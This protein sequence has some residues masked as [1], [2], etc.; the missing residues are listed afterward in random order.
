MSMKERRQHFRIDDTVFFDYKIIQSNE[1]CADSK[2]Y[3]QLLGEEGTRHLEAAKFF[4]DID[5]ELADISQSISNQ[6]PDILNFLKLINAKVDF[7]R[8]VFFSKDKSKLRPVNLGLGGM[9]FKTEK[10]IP[11]DSH[12]IVL[13]Y[14]KPKMIP[15]ILE[16]RVVYSKL[17]D[18]TGYRTAIA[19]GEL[20]PEKEKILANHIMQIQTQ[21]K[22]D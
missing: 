15:L 7:M 19:F 9:S 6:Y 5:Q 8:R 11:M 21:M 3:Q 18:Q 10:K 13:L 20:G 12:A 17:D 22:P 14:T 2:L 1:R 16:G 4:D